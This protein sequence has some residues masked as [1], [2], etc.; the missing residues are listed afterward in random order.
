[1]RADFALKR[2]KMY[3]LKHKCLNLNEKVMHPLCG[4]AIAQKSENFPKVWSFKANI[5]SQQVLFSQMNCTGEAAAADRLSAHCH[6]NVSGLPV[7]V[8][9]FR[10][11]RPQGRRC[12]GLSLTHASLAAQ[13]KGCHASDGH[14]ELR[15][16]FSHSAVPLLARLGVPSESSLRLQL[17]PGPRRRGL[18]VGLSLGPWGIDLNL[19]LRLESLGFYGWHGRLQLGS[20][21]LVRV[22][23][24]RGRLKFDSWCH[25]WTHVSAAMGSVTLGLQGSLRCKG[26]GRL[27]WLNVRRAEKGGEQKSSLTLNGQVGADGLKGLLALENELDSLRCTVLL[28]LKG[29]KL[30]F[31]WTLQHQWAFL[32]SVIPHRLD[33]QGSAHLADALWSG[34][35]RVSLNSRSAHI[36]ITA[37][38][39]NLRVTIKQ[40]L[41]SAG[42]PGALTVSLSSWADRADLEVD[43]DH[44]AVRVLAKRQR[45]GGV[46]GRN[47]WEVVALQR[48]IFL[49]VSEETRGSRWSLVS[50]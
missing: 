14:R 31:A 43:A 41:V 2:T 28:L 40:N 24:V 37:T 30:E 36:D 13:A 1:M 44:C 3:L 46:D 33:L 5:C 16:N 9:L 39:E 38:R 45:G 12:F 35:A 17:R 10:S 29:H 25:V 6:G 27:L 48:C 23:E 26:F 18:G 47:S 42:P 8:R 50:H 20:Q 15:L 34:T 49:K 19:G 7:E 4:P 21:G 11:H 22:A 32:T